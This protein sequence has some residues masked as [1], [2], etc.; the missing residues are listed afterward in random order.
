MA[1]VSLKYLVL[2]VFSVPSQAPAFR[3]AVPTGALKGAW[4]EKARKMLLRSSHNGE[5]TKEYLLESGLNRPN[6]E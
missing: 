1:Q 3:Q 2:E 6:S 5:N 4:E